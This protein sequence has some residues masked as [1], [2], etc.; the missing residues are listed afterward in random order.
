ME[1]IDAESVPCDNGD[2]FHCNDD[3]DRCIPLSMRCCDGYHWQCPGNA[4]EQ[5]CGTCFY[6]VE[7]YFT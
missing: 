4:D 2:V 7:Y 5:D 6:C 1:C 3:K